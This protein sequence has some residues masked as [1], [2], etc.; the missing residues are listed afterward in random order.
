MRPTP[1]AHR[2]N[3]L[4]LGPRCD[5][6]SDPKDARPKPVPRRIHRYPLAKATRSPRPR[7]RAN[8]TPHVETSITERAAPSGPARSVTP[9]SEINRPRKNQPKPVNR[10]ATED[11]SDSCNLRPNPDAARRVPHGTRQPLHDAPTHALRLHENS[12]DKSEEVPGCRPHS[13]RVS[14]N[15]VP[16][17]GRLAAIG[18]PK[19]LPCDR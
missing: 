14:C 17:Y 10:L 15:F 4:R 18:R 13:L 3:S 2:Q 1:R 8:P 7:T 6:P 19:P 9:A 11:G 5:Q 12:R 16:I